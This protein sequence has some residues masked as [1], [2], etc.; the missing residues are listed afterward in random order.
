MAPIEYEAGWAPEPFS[1]GGEEKNSQPLPGIEPPIIQPV[2]QR[3]TT[4]LCPSIV[5]AIYE[6]V[7]IATITSSHINYCYFDLM[8]LFP[9]LPKA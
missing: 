8:L 1:R 6:N 7:K 5:S 4:E 9:I 3:Y 2:A